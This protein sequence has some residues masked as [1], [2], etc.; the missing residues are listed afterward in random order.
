M[1]AGIVGSLLSM[2]FLAG[3]ALASDPND[4]RNCNSAEWRDQRI[5]AV[6][7]VTQPRVHFVKSPS[8]DDGKAEGCP[9]ATESCRMKSYLVTGDHVLVNKTQGDFTCVSYKAAQEK[10]QIWTTAW[11]PN[12]A[13]APVAPMPSPGKSDWIG[14]WCHPGCSIEITGAG[15]DKLHVEG[16]M[17][18]QAGRETRNGSFDAQV[19]PEN[20]SIA[21]DDGYDDGCKVRMQR[22]G[23]LLLVQDNG[24]C[25]G[26]GVTF[27]GLYSR[28]K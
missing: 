24:V 27:T 28:K 15:G 11:L 5:L 17:L 26:Y 13:L 3:P 16:L 7:K 18:V 21:F 2:I 14:K 23:A 22:V 10:A 12:A 6:A 4:P 20:G 9:A 25:G 1:R 8:D 19:A